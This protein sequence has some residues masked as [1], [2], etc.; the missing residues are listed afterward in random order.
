MQMGRRRSVGNSKLRT[1]RMSNRALSLSLSLAHAFSCSELRVAKKIN[2]PRRLRGLGDPE[3]RQ[4]GRGRLP[5]QSKGN[6]KYRYKWVWFEWWLEE[7]R[8]EAS[9]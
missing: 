2:R 1:A 5:M 4:T 8:K 7:K 6:A 9:K 3:I